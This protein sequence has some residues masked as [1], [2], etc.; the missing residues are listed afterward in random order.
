MI[1]RSKDIPD[2]EQLFAMNESKLDFEYIKFVLH[3]LL[4][5]EFD[6]TFAL[7]NKFKKNKFASKHNYYRL[8]QP[9]FR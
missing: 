6:L 3:T 2:L 1:V 4:P 7:Y 5:D 8:Q 9:C